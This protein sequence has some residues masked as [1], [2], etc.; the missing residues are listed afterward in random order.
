MCGSNRSWHFVLP[1]DHHLPSGGNRYNEQL[2]QALTRAGRSVRVVSW[3]AYQAARQADQAS[4]FFVD[5]LFVRELSR[6]PRFA[7]KPLRTIFVLHHLESMDPPLG[8]TRP[9]CR[10]EEQ[11]AFALVDAFLVTSSFSQQYLRTHGIRQPIVVVEPGITP[12]STLRPPPAHF[13]RALMVTNLI[14]RKGILPW[15]QQLATVVDDTDS[16]ELTIVGRTDLE[17]DYAAACQQAVATHPALSRKVRFSGALP[18]EQVLRHYAEAHVF[19]SAAR[20]ET[21]G[22]ALQ[23][24]K[25]YRVPLLTLAGGYAARHVAS[26]SDGYVFGELPEMAKFFVDFV[27]SPSARAAWQAKAAQQVP[28][29]VYGWD[30]AAQKLI[31]QLN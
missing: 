13:V 25:A 28:A 27:R 31:R 18:H 1:T 30:D 26:K 6:L 4:C 5:S 8:K 10:A 11:A 2:I 19:V 20:I 16:F 3:S 23:E 15:L 22:M 21:F 12:P 9:Q 7:T 24:A 29:T 14:T 17:P